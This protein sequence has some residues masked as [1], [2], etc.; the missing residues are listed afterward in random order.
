MKIGILGTGAYAVALAKVLVKNG[1]EVKMWTKFEDELNYIKENRSIKSI[2]DVTLEDEIEFTSNLEYIIS[3][4]SFIV[5]AI[6][7]NFIY[8]L[9]EEISKLDN[10]EEKTFCVASKGI[11]PNK[12]MFIS[13]IAKS[14]NFKH[15]GFV[16]GPTFASE[17]AKLVPCGLTLASNDQHIINMMKDA[18]KN[19]DIRIETT[20]DVVGIQLSNTLKNIFAIVMGILEEKNYSSST[21]ALVIT[22][23][24]NEL[25]N[26]IL[27]ISSNS[28]V[29]TSLAGI[30][31]IWLTC[32]STKSRNYTLGNIIASGDADKIN[33]Y[34]KNNTVE[35]YENLKNVLNLKEN[36]NLE[37]PLL[38][39]VYDIV[40]NKKSIDD[41]IK[42][43]TK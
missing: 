14:F 42:L 40:N 38:E 6:P 43:I 16:S 11:D 10:V 13:D 34:L 21:K 26:A 39:Y 24:I 41:L 25:N 12:N 3:S 22:S 37:F 5:I 4:S 1:H 18:F 32:T 15:I 19:D 17:M 27:K 7:S 23:L 35:G 8:G 36:Y 31:D 33:D 9:F 2:P 30:G 28:N 29:V 20:N